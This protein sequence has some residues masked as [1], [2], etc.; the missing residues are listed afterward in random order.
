[1]RLNDKEEQIVY[2]KETLA[3]FVDISTKD[4]TTGATSKK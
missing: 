2:L 1:L 3:K 4:K